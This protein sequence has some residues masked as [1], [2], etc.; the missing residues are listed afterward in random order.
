MPAG[1]TTTRA[2]AAGAGERGSHALAGV[3]DRYHPLPGMSNRGVASFPALAQ[4][5]R[6]AGNPC[7]LI[8]AASIPIACCRIP[9]GNASAC[10]A[11]GNSANT[12]RTRRPTP[13][14]SPA[15]WGKSCVPQG[16]NGVHYPC[17]GGARRNKHN[18]IPNTLPGVDAVQS[19][20]IYPPR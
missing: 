5:H 15:K 1:L 13:D 20:S 14:R 6:P 19:N 9:A 10:T 12:A 4:Q 8:S 16:R 2:G 11:V 18:T 3:A 17:Y 7:C